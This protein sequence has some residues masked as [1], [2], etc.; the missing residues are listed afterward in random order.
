MSIAYWNVGKK[1]FFPTSWGNKLDLIYILG[2][3]NWDVNV[4][5]IEN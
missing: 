3:N 4:T 2:E 1:V 5:L